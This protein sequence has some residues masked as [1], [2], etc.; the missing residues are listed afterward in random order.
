MKTLG[1]TIAGALGL[2]A[3]FR[4]ANADQLTW[5]LKPTVVLGELLSRTPFSF[6]PGVG[7]LDPSLTFQVVPA[8]SGLN[9]FCVAWVSAVAMLER[10]VASNGLLVVA[11]AVGAYA[12]TVLANAIR[13]TLALAVHLHHVSFGFVT[14][15]RLHEALGVLVYLSMLMLA[16][17][18]VHRRVP[19]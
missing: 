10:R 5:L 3:W 7:Y 16:T 11:T 4:D 17:Q 13:I 18:L 9:F 15:P 19:A 14:A 12:L 8:C 1:F 6:E 2:K